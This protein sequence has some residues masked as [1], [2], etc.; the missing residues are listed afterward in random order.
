MKKR[1]MIK[2][3]KAGDKELF[4]GVYDIKMYTRFV[5]TLINN[6]FFQRTNTLYVLNY[7]SFRLAY[8]I[9]RKM[10]GG[11][12]M[13]K[14]RKY[15]EID[16]VF[17]TTVPSTLGCSECAF[18]DKTTPC[19]YGGLCTQKGVLQ[20][21]EIKPTKETQK[22][23]FNISKRCPMGDIEEDGE[24]HSYLDFD[25]FCEYILKHWNDE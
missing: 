7:K 13:S 16:G 3:A 9:H 19:E 24:Y 17:Y 6:K 22:K 12:N 18:Y 21:V 14:I 4:N 1:Q 23:V 11:L 8:K 20:K 10:H 5:Y 25:S 15:Y 2:L